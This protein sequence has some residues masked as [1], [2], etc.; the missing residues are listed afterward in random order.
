MSSKPANNM[1]SYADQTQPKGR[2][3]SMD[4]VM[5]DS[6]ANKEE[7]RIFRD[8]AYMI[9]LDGAVSV[10]KMSVKGVGENKVSLSHAAI[11]ANY[12]QAKEGTLVNLLI[13]ARNRKN[14]GWDFPS[15]GGEKC[16]KGVMRKEGIFWGQACDR[17]VE[18]PVLRVDLKDSDDEATCGM[19]D[20][21][22]DGKDWSA[23]DKKKQ[24]RYIVDDSTSE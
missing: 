18:Y 2:Y 19:D 13:W 10:R 4:F 12:S 3:V 22:E 8:H 20:E 21:Q 23:S 17:A 5:S 11:H 15:C 6:K 1:S 14:D 24:K 16:K 7:Y 9:E